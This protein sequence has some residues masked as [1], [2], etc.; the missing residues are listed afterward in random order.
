[1]LSHSYVNLPEGNSNSMILEISIFFKN[2]KFDG[3]LLKVAMSRQKYG[4]RKKTVR[5][6]ISTK[7]GS[8]V[9]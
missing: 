4:N 2:I 5:F 3:T 9:D 7:T 6:L 8:R 1:M